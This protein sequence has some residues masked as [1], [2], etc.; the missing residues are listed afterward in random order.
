[1]GK[2]LSRK[3]QSLVTFLPTCAKILS[4][5]Q[6]K[7]TAMYSVAFLSLVLY[8]GADVPVKAT[9]EAVQAAVKK[10]L[11]LLLKGAKGHIAQKTCFACHNQ[12]PPVLALTTAR[13][14]GFDVGDV[15]L[16]EQMQFIANFLDG[17]RE[18]YQRGKGQGGAADTAGYALWTLELGGWQP[19]ET[20]AAV[21]EYLLLHSKDFDHWRNAGNRPPSEASNFTV[22][23]FALRGLQKWGTPEQKERIAKRTDALRTWLLKTPARD[24]EDRVFRLWALQAAGV[25]SK[26]IAPAVH[27]LLRT[28]RQDGGWGQLDG[29]GSD[30][31]A[32]GSALVVLHLAG[33]L[34]TD[35]AVYQ[36]GLAFLIGS[37]REDGSWFVKSRS[38]PFQPYYES[39]F[40]HGKDQFISMAASGWAVTALALAS[41]RLEKR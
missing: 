19:D 15:E 36:R 27:D 41:P 20:T 7:V 24:T 12:A 29:A 5:P 31:Y 3:R 22:S 40:P 18:N 35:H 9:P 33:G 30:A 34:P 16:K 2:L 21:S 28:Q 39:G 14:R 6:H 1:M 4:H 26:K 38:K 8:A 17:N 13:D 11:P 37:Q 23:F 10:G 25:G 32:T